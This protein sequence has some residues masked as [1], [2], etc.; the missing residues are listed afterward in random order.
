MVAYVTDHEPFW[1]SSGPD[2]QHPG[3]QRH[4]E[5]IRDLDLLIHD[6]QYSEEEYETKVGWGHSPIG[7]VQD[8]A[9][10]AGVHRLALF[11]HDPTH[12][13]GVARPHAE[14]LPGKGSGSVARR[15]KSSPPPKG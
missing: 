12:D 9:L 13:D 8:V 4:V 14:R 5:F 10:A 6:A 2:F 7:Y 15:W 11:H 3:D 1:K